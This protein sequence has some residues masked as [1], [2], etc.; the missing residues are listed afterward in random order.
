MANA[1][2]HV[3][4]HPKYV[5]GGIDPRYGENC[6]G[7]AY[8]TAPSDLKKKHLLMNLRRSTADRMSKGMDGWCGRAV[9]LF[10][11]QDADLIFIKRH[12]ALVAY[13]RKYKLYVII[14]STL[15]RGVIKEPM[16]Q[17]VRV[18]DPTA[19]RLVIHQRCE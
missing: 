10:D 7:M 14:H 1:D 3:A 5:R 11:A 2:Y 16:P 9:S 4:M 17:W 13:S 18:K 8:A 19:R 15:S 12:V 6:S